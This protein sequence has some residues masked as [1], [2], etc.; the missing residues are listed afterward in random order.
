M[1]LALLAVLWLVH[2]TLAESPPAPQW[3]QLGERA[4]AAAESNRPDEAARL[5]RRALGV[6]PDWDEGWWSLGTLYYE[7]NRYRECRESFLRFT[8]I[9]KKS[10]PAYV[11]LG[12]CEFQLED[13]SAALR[14]IRRGEELGLPEDSQLTR[15]AYYHEALLLT[16]LENY[17][18]ALFLLSLLIKDGEENP[19]AVA[20]IGIA[21][22][23]R[24]VFPKELPEA[25]RPLA[26]RVGNAVALGFQRRPTDA[27]R[28]FESLVADHPTVPNL[29]YTFGT[30]LQGQDADAAIQAW[31]SELKVSP[32]H[33]P[34]LV[35][36]AFEYLTRGDTASAR[37]YA[38]LAMK[39]AP[40]HFMSR[41]AIGRVLL[42]S[43]DHNSA[44]KHLEI[45]AKLS[46]DSPQ[47]RLALGTAYSRAGRQAEAAR[48]RDAFAALKKTRSS[49]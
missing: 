46:P 43:G 41:A 24:P 6:K 15:V 27:R 32:G 17:E 29:H 22:L 13:Y 20:A 10:G 5:Y 16:K 8:S 7:Q 45:A 33:L 2:P 18:R 48:E 31:K 25:D 44:I 12:L 14:N 26:L 47:I 34:S 40:G 42:D 23:R 21:A 9:N 49:Q 28:E 39:A 3:K 11:M 38:E 35:S 4:K 1:S 30:F 36:L 37:P 19:G